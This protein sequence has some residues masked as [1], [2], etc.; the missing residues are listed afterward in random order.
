VL[1]FSGYVVFDWDGI[2]DTVDHDALAHRTGSGAVG[3]AC[4][5]N[6]IELVAQIDGWYAQKFTKLVALLAGLP[7]GDGSVLDNTA[8]LW[9]QEFS[10]G[11]AMN[12][13]NMPICIAGSAGGAL[14][15]GVAVNVEGSPIG[16]G[17]SEATC[18]SGGNVDVSAT[19]STGGN[20]PIN[21]LYV[22]LMNA[23]GCRDSEGNLLTTFGVFDGDDATAGITNP[24]ELES[25]KA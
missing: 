9:L 22:T 17:N 4:Y 2:H 12:L 21:K 23:L 19:G 7:E 24:G 18:Q 10:D 25:L 5:P 20:V 14:K 13:N 15:Q 1:N 3:G 6:V 11:N 16:P 8:T